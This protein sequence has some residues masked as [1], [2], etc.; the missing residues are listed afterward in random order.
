MRPDKS[1]ILEATVDMLTASIGTSTMPSG[2]TLLTVA[3]PDKT[4]EIHLDVGMARS[5]T[6]GLSPKTGGPIARISDESGVMCTIVMDKM[7]VV[8]FGELR[9]ILGD[10]VTIAALDAPS[11][12]TGPLTISS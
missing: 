9:A 4:F 10:T 6:L 7:K 3:S 12:N 11:G 8:E 1:V 5:A 2:S